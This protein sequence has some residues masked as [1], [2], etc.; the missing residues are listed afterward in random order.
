MAK[1]LTTYRL[2][3]V[4]IKAIEKVS[5]QQLFMRWTVKGV[6]PLIQAPILL[7]KIQDS[8]GVHGPTAIGISLLA[9]PAPMHLTHDDPRSAVSPDHLAAPDLF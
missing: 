5:I 7:P 6:H 8:L 3:E 9:S 1:A 4:V 2:V